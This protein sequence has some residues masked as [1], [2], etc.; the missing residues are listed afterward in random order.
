M[1]SKKQQQQQQQHELFLRCFELFP[2]VFLVVSCGF[3]SVEL[4]EAAEL[5]DAAEPEEKWED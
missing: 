3:S 4:E 2:Q 1:S 5:T